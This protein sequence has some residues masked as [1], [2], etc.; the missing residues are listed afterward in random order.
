MKRL[1]KI[2]LPSLTA[3]V[4][5]CSTQQQKIPEPINV[6]LAQY[7][8]LP[9]KNHS[10][11]KSFKYEGAEV[12]TDSAGP[13]LSITLS[14]IEFQKN[15]KIIKRF[16]GICV[17]INHLMQM[18]DLDLK[19]IKNRISFRN[20]LALEYGFNVT[21]FDALLD[22]LVLKEESLDFNSLTEIDST[23]ARLQRKRFNPFS[24]LYLFIDDQLKEDMFI[25]PENNDAD[26]LASDIYN[27]HFGKNPLLP[28]SSRLSSLF[29]RNYRSV[30]KLVLEDKFAYNNPFII[31]SK[32]KT[33]DV[34][35]RLI[36]NQNNSS[37]DSDEINYILGDRLV[38]ESGL[39]N[40]RFIRIGE[41]KSNNLYALIEYYC[42]SASGVYI[43]MSTQG[44][45]KDNLLTTKK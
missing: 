42:T 40:E 41:K 25:V 37:F 2:L 8:T 28:Y 17:D 29:Q 14:S 26:S 21:E 22:I 6:P 24:I 3:L 13:Y 35:K 36:D 33:G 32:R 38:N 45:L 10:L 1:T 4:I 7:T 39:V 23:F 19:D 30:T 12:V 34:E 31:H 5:G 11:P 20:S 27:L 44:L 18:S 15:Q 9:L 43:R 16:E